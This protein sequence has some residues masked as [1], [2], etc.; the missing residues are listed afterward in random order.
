MDG[1][2]VQL[3]I[4][5]KLENIFI[6]Y[7]LTFL[8]KHLNVNNVINALLCYAFVLASMYRYSWLITFGIFGNF[9]SG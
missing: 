8:G 5:K 3:E 7:F 4:S 2:S 6:H 9:F 1:P